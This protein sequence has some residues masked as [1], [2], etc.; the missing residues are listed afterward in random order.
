MC[1]IIND[2][3]CDTVEQ[4]QCRDVPEEVCEMV[5][6]PQGLD[7]K[8]NKL[9]KCGPDSFSRIVEMWTRINVM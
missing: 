7:E 2:Q 1:S 9:L 6:Q 4:N 8:P 5:A 3:Q